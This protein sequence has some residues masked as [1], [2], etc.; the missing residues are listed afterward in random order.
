MEYSKPNIPKRKNPPPIMPEIPMP[1]QT[2]GQSTHRISDG[3][4]KDAFACQTFDRE[5]LTIMDF[6]LKKPSVSQ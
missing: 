4:P 5:N 3:L 2:P 1:P 6:A